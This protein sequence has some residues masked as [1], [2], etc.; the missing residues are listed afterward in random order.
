MKYFFGAI[1][2]AYLITARAQLDRKTDEC[3][4]RE[5]IEPPGVY[6]SAESPGTYMAEI[7]K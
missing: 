3:Q 7:Y 4:G 1:L 6:T 5:K 2:F